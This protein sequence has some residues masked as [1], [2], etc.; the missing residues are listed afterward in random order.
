M[1]TT[2]GILLSYSD[3]RPYRINCQLWGAQI[4]TS[5]THY[6]I[7]RDADGSFSAVSVNAKSGFQLLRVDTNPVVYGTSR[8]SV[9]SP[10]SNHQMIE[11]PLNP[12]AAAKFG[13]PL[14]PEFCSQ[15]IPQFERIE[16]R[17]GW[18]L[19]VLKTDQLGRLGA[20][21]LVNAIVYKGREPLKLEDGSDA[22][23]LSVRQRAPTEVLVAELAI[24]RPSFGRIAPQ[25]R[26]VPSVDGN[27]ASELAR[28]TTNFPVFETV[29]DLGPLDEVV[30]V[31]D[32]RSYR[33]ILQHVYHKLDWT[34]SEFDI[35]RVT[36]PYPIL[37]T[38]F[39]VWFPL[40]N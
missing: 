33:S 18:V 5:L 34:Q 8:T 40:A 7:R 31:G 29:T 6:S 23:F 20:V 3:E 21:D 25:L 28:P 10:T 24:H 26:V 1:R 14:L 35:Y 32:V 12:E 36:V 4:G 39:A 11:R 37:S 38:D 17:N 19:H 27:L 16:A 13:S 15:P 22:L 30:P 2:I 9:A